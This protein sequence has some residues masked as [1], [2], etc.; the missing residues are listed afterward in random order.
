MTAT[1]PEQTTPSAF[2]LL[3]K[4]IS[5]RESGANRDDAWYQVCDAVGDINDVT[6]KAFLNLAK[7]WERR[8]GHKYRY[9]SPDKKHDTLT[10]KELTQVTEQAQQ[11]TRQ[12][13]Q[14]QA[15]PSQPKPPARPD[16]AL[17]G[18]LDPA[19]L[20]AQDQQR[21]DQILDQ[22]DDL[23]E[24]DDSEPPPQVQPQTATKGRTAPMRYQPGFFGSRTALLMYFKNYPKPLRVTI[25][26]EAELFIGRATSNA[27]MSPEID[28]N[29]V[30]AANFGVSRMHAAITR[31][32]NQL[33]ICDL[34]SMNYTYVN[35]MRLL[36]DEA[37]ILQD[38]DE[39]WF[40][41]LRCQIRFQQS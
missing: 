32:N 29:A 19:R 7:N 31:R 23:P 4:F 1:K 3:S 34:E 28:L 17:T 15:P 40:G 33:L 30:N 26:G 10:E 25:A 13:K 39:I 22:L 6:R 16:N 41:Q 8:E 11:Q 27:A 18:V 12:K 35:G 9:S 38:G 37:R 2:D 20:R 14:R 36:P 24:E 5:L 21:L